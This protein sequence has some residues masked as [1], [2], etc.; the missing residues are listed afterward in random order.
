MPAALF[1]FRGWGIILGIAFGG[2]GFLIAVRVPSNPIGWI[3]LLAGAGTAL[4]ELA[5]QYLLYG[6]YDSPGAAPR[7]DIAAWI[8]EWI[9]IPY[10]ATVAFV[11]PL[12]YPTGRLPSP[13]WR[14]ALVA[15]LAAAALGTV[16]FALVPGPMESTRALPIR[17]GSTEQRGSGRWGTS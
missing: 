17:S 7:P 8:V 12:I 1:G 2:A 16:C 6:M 5:L 14:P 3:L 4:Q 9:W 11:I 13:R 10:M 15:G